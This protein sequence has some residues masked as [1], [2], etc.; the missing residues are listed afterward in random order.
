MF[1]ELTDRKYDSDARA[2]KTGDKFLLDFQSGW[3]IYDNGDGPAS[4]VNMNIGQ[5]K[6][7]NETYR[8]IREKLIKSG[9]LMEDV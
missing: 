1:I 9:M 7:V 4:W 2:Y 5:N 8:Q 6:S 3:E